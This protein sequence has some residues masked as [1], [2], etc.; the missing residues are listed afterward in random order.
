MEDNDPEIRTD[1][2]PVC[3]HCGAIQ[4]DFID[5]RVF[6]DEQELDEECASCGE[7]YTIVVHVKFSF[8]TGKETYKS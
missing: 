7:D 8:S 3:P 5:G 6:Y 2:A 4:K 1:D